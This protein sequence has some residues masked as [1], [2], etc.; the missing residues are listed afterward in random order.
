MCLARELRRRGELV[1]DVLV[2]LA[3]DLQVERQH[4]R[5]AAGGLGPVDQVEHEIPVVHHVEL[6]PERLLRVRGDILDRADAHRR[7]RERNAEFLGRLRRQDFAVGVLHAGKAGGRQRHGHRHLLADHGAFERAVGH[8]DQHA[9]AELDL[10]KV[11]L[12]G[13]IGAFGPGAGIGVIEEHLRHA[14]AGKVLQVVDFDYLG[15]SCCFSRFRAGA[16]MRRQP[17]LGSVV[18]RLLAFRAPIGGPS[19]M[20]ASTSATWR[21]STC[22]P[23]ASAF[24]PCPS[25]SRDRRQAACPRRRLLYRPS[26]RVALLAARAGCA[27]DAAAEA[28]A[29]CRV[30]HFDQPDAFD[31]LR[32]ACAA[33][34][35]TPRSCRPA[36]ASW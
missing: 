17:S 3:E 34:P 24:R 29:R 27:P 15:H 36:Q 28:A 25:G 33:A 2:A 7:Q 32:A 12:V 21:T 23:G 16:T 22:E 13:A 6:E 20:P 4:Q 31:R 10:G 1:A 11:R 9:L 26:C 14:P 8:V 5:R 35:S 30:S 19:T 18:C